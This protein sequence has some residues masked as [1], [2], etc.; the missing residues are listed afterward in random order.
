MRTIARIILLMAVLVSSG[1]LNAQQS[2]ADGA[3]LSIDAGAKVTYPN[4]LL[5][6]NNATLV[7][8]G[9]LE[10]KGNL[11]ILPSCT[12]QNNGVLVLHGDLVNTAGPGTFTGTGAVHL[13]GQSLQSV[14]GNVTANTI[15]VSNPAGVQTYDTLLVADSLELL[16]GNLT[17]LTSRVVLGPSA[18]LYGESNTARVLGEM[19]TARNV[20][21]NA[22]EAFGNMGY[23]L[24]TA[25]TAPG[26]TTVL[27][28]TGPNVTGVLV[29]NPRIERQWEATCANNGTLGAQLVLNYLDVEVSAL[30]ESDLGAFLSTDGGFTWMDAVEAQ[31]TSLNT[32]TI[33]G[34]NTLD[35]AAMSD[36]VNSPITSSTALNEESCYGDDGSVQLSPDG[37][38]APYSFAWDINANSQ[39]T[40]TATGLKEGTY[41]ATVTDANGC[42][43]KLTTTLGKSNCDSLPYV[44]AKYC[45]DTLDAL[46]SYIII[47][48]VSTAQG[49]QYCAISPTGDTLIGATG[50]GQLY[51]ALSF[52]QGIANNT[53]YTVRVRALIGGVWTDYGPPCEITTPQSPLTRLKVCNLTLNSM[54]QY[55]YA[56][57]VPGAQKYQFMHVDTA[58]SDTLYSFG[59]GSGNYTAALFAGLQF[60]TTYQVQVRARVGDVWGD[61]GQKCWLTTPG[62]PFAQFYGCP[63]TLNTLNQYIYY[64]QI[65]GANSYRF[66]IVN[67]GTG[68]IDTAYFSYNGFYSL[69][70]YNAAQPGTTYQIS[71]AGYVNNMWQPFGPPCTVITPA[72]KESDRSIPPAHWPSAGGMAERIHCFPN[73]TDGPLTVVLPNAIPLKVPLRSMLFDASGRMVHQVRSVNTN[74][75]LE[76]NLQSGQPIAPGLYVLQLWAG[77]RKWYQRIVVQ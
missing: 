10:L 54:S 44:R 8:D 46:N 69:Y 12:V 72:F 49:Y 15:Q 23:T 2:I 25:A 77:E 43:V 75:Q 16:Q 50:G 67:T 36:E 41:S 27:R 47:E 29:C 9:A 1:R 30:Q 56:Q 34:V 21:S 58:T 61:Y 38:T 60:S 35:F 11:T 70:F 51:Y 73:P 20:A 4:D 42:S 33:N 48:G 59:L 66:Q 76:L 32:L 57:V 45:G 24:N 62:I 22:T 17:T 3:Q 6:S 68:A 40:G 39:T 28:R 74:Q 37:G 18:A 19:I 53:T 71:I 65:A 13:V 31:N 14:T 52:L 55:Y 63:I 5:L 26:T 7:I 64:S